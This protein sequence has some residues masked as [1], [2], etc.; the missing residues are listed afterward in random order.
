MNTELTASTNLLT[1]ILPPCLRGPQP[2]DEVDHEWLEFLALGLQLESASPVGQ[3][4]WRHPPVL[5]SY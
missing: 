5:L 4:P 2:D 3:A 1:A